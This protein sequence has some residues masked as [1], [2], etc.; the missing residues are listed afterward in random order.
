MFERP[1]QGFT[2]PLD[3]WFGNGLRASV[4]SLARSATLSD[5]QWFRPEGIRTLVR[6]HLAGQRDHSQRIYNLLV[7]ERWLQNG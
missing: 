3:R 2:V 1:K 6:E 4:E 5:T 7:L